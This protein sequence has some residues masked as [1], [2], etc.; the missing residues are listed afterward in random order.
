MDQL[1]ASVLAEIDAA[2]PS[3]QGK[4]VAY[5]QAQAEFAEF[6]LLRAEAKK[7]DVLADEKQ[8]DIDKL[9]LGETAL[10]GKYHEVLNMIDQTKTEIANQPEVAAR[11]K[12]ASLNQAD[13][14]E[15][16][17]VWNIIGQVARNQWADQLKEHE[18]QMVFLD[19]E[20]DAV[21]AEIK[22]LR[23]KSNEMMKA[24]GSHMVEGNKILKDAGLQVKPI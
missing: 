3:L 22:E 8:G 16:I 7:L 1:F 24:A 4:E 5:E 17:K 23:K 13:G 14:S 19:G 2:V 9:K 20:I 10:L 18:D 12:M 21:K 11:L 15:T 6:T